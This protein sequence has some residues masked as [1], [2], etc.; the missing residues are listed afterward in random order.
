VTGNNYAEDN[1]WSRLTTSSH[2]PSLQNWRT[3]SVEPALRVQKM[4]WIDD[5]SIYELKLP[6]Y[7]QWETRVLAVSRT[8]SKTTKK[9]TCLDMRW[10]L[11][12]INRSAHTTQMAE[13][14][15]PHVRQ[16]RGTSYDWAISQRDHNCTQRCGHRAARTLSN[17]S[18]LQQ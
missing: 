12:E 16:R 9:T 13:E 2:Q 18:T 1:R 8:A 5:E 4:R 17:L 7:R 15:I 10:K 3:L 14:A 6:F 11:P